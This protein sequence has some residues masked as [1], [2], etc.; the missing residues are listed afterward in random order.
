MAL[1]F[2]FVAN[3]D[4]V[5]VQVDGLSEKR[6]RNL[7]VL[8]LEEHHDRQAVDDDK[9]GKC[10]GVGDDGADRWQEQGK[11]QGDQRHDQVEDDQV[12]LLHRLVL[13]EK[14]EQL[15]PQEQVE[16]RIGRKE[17]HKHSQAHHEGLWLHVSKHIETV[18]VDL[19]LVAGLLNP[20]E[21]VLKQGADKAHV[22]HRPNKHVAEEHYRVADKDISCSVL[23]LLGVSD[24]WHSA[25]VQV[26]T[27]VEQACQRREIGGEEDE[28]AIALET[29]P[30][31]LLVLERGAKL[32]VGCVEAPATH[33]DD[34]DH[35][36]AD[37]DGAKAAKS[38]EDAQVL[39]GADCSEQKV[40]PYSCV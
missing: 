2:F 33:D 37:E 6:I 30:D 35:V 10:A 27:G 39:L 19:A 1:K 8:L 32:V 3:D 22:P 25:R 7:D 28:D 5:V 26:V 12:A 29:V 16:H 20:D 23:R 9:A 14:V 24:N 18:L 13:E 11:R 38:D 4:F 15:R 17:H 34:A 40:E 36:H 21:V 31:C